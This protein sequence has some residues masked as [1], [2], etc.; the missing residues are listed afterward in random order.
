MRLGTG[1][2]FRIDDDSLLIE[3]DGGR[4]FRREQDGDVLFFEV[5]FDLNVHNINTLLGDALGAHIT[6]KLNYTDKTILISSIGDGPTVKLYHP[7]LATI[8]FLKYLSGPIAAYFL[9]MSQDE[10]F[11]DFTRKYQGVENG[12][13][14]S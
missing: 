13:R 10:P 5:M 9:A 12:V 8:G 4:I 2:N 6:G 1:S 3:I 14:S 11:L 7:I